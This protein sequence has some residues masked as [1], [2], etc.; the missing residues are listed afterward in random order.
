MA[1]HLHKTS[2]MLVS[3]LE[4]ASARN[5]DAVAVEDG[6]PSTAARI[7]GLLAASQLVGGVSPAVRSELAKRARLTTL[8]AG[9]LLWRQGD[10]ATHMHIIGRGLVT[11]RRT[12]EAGSASIVAIFGAR[13]SV[14]DTAALE[15]ARYP[16]EAIV[17]STE[18]TVVRLD[19]TVVAARAR[20]CAALAE[21]LQGSLLRHNAALRVKVDILSAGSVRARLGHLFLHLVSRFGDELADG[22]I[23]LP[24]ALTRVA[25]A[26]LVAARVETVVRALRPWERDGTL[27]TSPDGFVIGDLAG[28]SAVVAGSDGNGRRPIAEA[29]RRR[30]HV[31]S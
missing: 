21:A 4:Q 9:E 5:V 27:V 13:E 18:A 6:Y 31:T 24:V 26:D 17:I 7:E 10:L 8:R 16:A 3:R 30:G 28:L 1:P 20:T 15:S 2:R 25:I 23:Y 29:L 12:S 11:I 19:A 22:S 14:G